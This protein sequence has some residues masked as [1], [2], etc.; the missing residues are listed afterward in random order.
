MII[1]PTV[2]L[3]IP[4]RRWHQDM[5]HM[6]VESYSMVRLDMYYLQE[7]MVEFTGIADFSYEIRSTILDARSP[8]IS[9]LVIDIKT[10]KTIQE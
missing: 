6:P 1:F 5:Q 9:N 2:Q 8:R 4:L 7:T 10:R 3:N